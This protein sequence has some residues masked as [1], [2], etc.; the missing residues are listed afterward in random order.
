MNKNLVIWLGSLVGIVIVLLIVSFLQ[1]FPTKPTWCTFSKLL[2]DKR[3]GVRGSGNDRST[4]SVS[5][6]AFPDLYAIFANNII[7]DG[8]TANYNSTT[9]SYTKGVEIMK[10]KGLAWQRE[11]MRATHTIYLPECAYNSTDFPWKECL[12]AM[13]IPSPVGTFW[14][15]IGKPTVGSTDC[16]PNCNVSKHCCST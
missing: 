4:L 12:A 9:H 5:K 11:R 14:A 2:R 7:G 3:V 13:H 15:S 6:G 1:I 8:K 10:Q 16:F